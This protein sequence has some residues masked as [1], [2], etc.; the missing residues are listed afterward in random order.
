MDG[1]IKGPPGSVQAI[2]NRMGEVMGKIWEKFKAHDASSADSKIIE[3]WSPEVEEVYGRFFNR[4]QEKM[5]DLFDIA[6][7]GS[8]KNLSK[9][10]QAQ[11]GHEFL[12]AVEWDNYRAAHEASVAAAKKTTDPAVA[13]ASA[14]RVKTSDV[15]DS[16]HAAADGT[17][18]KKSIKAALDSGMSHEEVRAQ[19]TA[20][21]D[22]MQPVGTLVSG[23]PD[24]FAPTKI[25]KKAPNALKWAETASVEDIDRKSTRLNSSH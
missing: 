5:T 2:F 20:L 21:K 12:G 23:T 18:T 17:V 13:A 22:E 16:I 3:T 9:E 10:T 11:L 19:L 6:F 15:V 7:K 14:P 24:V 1:R 25:A 8:F 4:G